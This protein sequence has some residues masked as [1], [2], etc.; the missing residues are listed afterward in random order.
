MRCPAVRRNGY[1][2]Y[3]GRS[4]G[5]TAL[6]VLIGVLLVLLV[7]SVAALFFLERAALLRRR[8]DGTRF[9]RGYRSH[10][11]GHAISHAIPHA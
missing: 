9:P 10:P 4:R 3:H 7:L 1:E 8:P 5:R 2:S 6:K 11:G